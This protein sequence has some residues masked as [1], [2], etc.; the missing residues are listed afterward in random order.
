M[1]QGI[2]AEPLTFA[3]GK[4]AKE[5]GV[6]NEEDLKRLLQLGKAKEQSEKEKKEK[7]LKRKEAETLYDEL[8]SRKPS[9]SM[10]ASDFDTPNNESA[11]ATKNKAESNR[12]MDMEEMLAGFEEKA[13]IQ[14]EELEEVAMLRDNVSSSQKYSYD[15]LYSLMELEAKAQ[16]T[17]GDSGH[18]AIYVSFE[19]VLSDAN[20]EN[21]L[22]L[23]GASRTI[24]SAL[25]DIDGIPVTFY[26]RNGDK[27]TIEFDAASV[28]DDM[29]ILKSN[30]DLSRIRNNVAAIGRAEINVD[31]PIEL[32]KKWKISF[33]TLILKVTI[34]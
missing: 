14:R 31:K 12:N 23:K 21:V 7:E 33:P 27:Q 34:L 10:K 1:M 6:K 15:W 28:K 20:K 18:R 2:N 4:L 17:N 16:G 26:L 22:I 11:R 24:P 25:E 13:Q 19:H 9:L 30:L 8:P 29:I 3:F 32:I 5:L